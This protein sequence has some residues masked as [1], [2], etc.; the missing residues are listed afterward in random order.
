[1]FANIHTKVRVEGLLREQIFRFEIG[2][3]WGESSGH[4]STDSEQWLGWFTLFNWISKH[5]FAS[6]FGLR[7]CS[8]DQ[9]LDFGE[10]HAIL[11]FEPVAD[12][13]RFISNWH[14]TWFCVL[15]IGR[16]AHQLLFADVTVFM[17]KQSEKREK[18]ENLPPRP[19]KKPPQ[20]ADPKECKLRGKVDRPVKSSHTTCS[21]KH[22]QSD[23]TETRFAKRRDG[24]PGRHFF[25]V[26]SNPVS[27]KFAHEFRFANL[28][29][30]ASQ[31]STVAE[32]A[33]PG[34]CRNLGGKKLVLS[35]KEYHPVSQGKEEN[36]R[37]LHLIRFVYNRPGC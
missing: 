23:R 20:T 10:W 3:S 24:S 29:S 12:G 4:G 27:R 26:A 1:M 37:D 33:E 14:W 8:V 31:T 28:P 32:L 22:Q 16:A 18:C 7:W 5:F 13:N 19:N 15:R 21:Q 6:R 35:R 30:V 2:L 11:L 34:L 36:R 17:R 9:R 25:R